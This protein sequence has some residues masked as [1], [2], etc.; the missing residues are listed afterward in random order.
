MLTLTIYFIALNVSVEFVLIYRPHP[1]IAG[2]WQIVV[3]YTYDILEVRLTGLSE[4]IGRRVLGRHFEELC[5]P[6]SPLGLFY[7]LSI[8]PLREREKDIISA[9]QD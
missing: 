3:G 9:C 1:V 4:H 8:F 2:N 5:C 6:P 7:I